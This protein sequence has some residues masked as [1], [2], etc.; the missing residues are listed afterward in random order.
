MH[1]AAP[2]LPVVFDADGGPVR[3][4]NSLGFYSDFLADHD[5]GAREFARL[6]VGQLR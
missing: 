6:Y 3:A 2:H 1:I 4:E 5:I